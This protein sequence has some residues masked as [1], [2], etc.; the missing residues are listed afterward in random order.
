MHLT[1][2]ISCK[3]VPA[4][5]YLLL[6]WYSLGWYLDLHWQDACSC[7]NTMSCGFSHRCRLPT[8]E[9]TCALDLTETPQLWIFAFLALLLP[10]SIS[11]CLCQYGELHQRWSDPTCLV[12]PLLGLTLR[13]HSTLYS[14][15]NGSMMP[16][17]LTGR[18]EC[19]CKRALHWP[20]ACKE[21]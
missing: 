11:V 5:M 7:D 17:L 20:V 14:P 10:T 2:E 13:S 21:A 9:P 18:V 1:P 15:L 6:V 3:V 4:C 8:C 19:S 12:I 16:S